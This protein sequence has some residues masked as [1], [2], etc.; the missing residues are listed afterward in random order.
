VS[1]PLIQDNW[2]PR[3][4]IFLCGNTVSFAASI[5]VIV[6]LLLQ[7]LHDNKW[8]LSRVMNTMMVLDLLGLLVAYVAGACRTLKT[9]EYVSALIVAVLAYFSIFV[10]LSLLRRNKASEGAASASHAS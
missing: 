2:R 9:I 5:V 6:L 1:N 4:L 7:L 3:Y 10:T 8:L